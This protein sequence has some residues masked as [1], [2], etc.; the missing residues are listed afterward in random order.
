MGI[1]VVVKGHEKEVLATLLTPR[2]KH[3]KLEGDAIQIVHALQ[4]EVK[5]WCQYDLLIEDARVMLNILQL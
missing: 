1:G 5:N 2:H 4:K 3:V